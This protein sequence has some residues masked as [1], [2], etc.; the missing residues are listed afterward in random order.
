M[1]VMCVENYSGTAFISGLDDIWIILSL[2]QCMPQV[3]GDGRTLCDGVS[4]SSSI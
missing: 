4:K 2:F 1:V 3:R